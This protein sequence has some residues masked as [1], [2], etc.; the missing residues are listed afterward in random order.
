MK[1]Q[2]AVKGLLCLALLL[3]LQGRALAAVDIAV[4]SPWL[5]LMTRFIGGLQ[6][7]VHPL[8]GWDANGRV[9]RYSRP[10]GRFPVIALDES[11]ARSYGVR[12][13]SSKTLFE[14]LPGKGV[15]ESS[16]LDPS[17]LAFIGQRLL[18]TLSSIDPAN[19]AYYQR[20]LAEFQSRTDT[21][22]DV[23]RKLLHGLT[24]LDLTGASGKW[25]RAAVQSP[26]TPPEHV[27]ELW[28]KG[29]SLESLSVALRD[30]AAKGWIVVV[31]SWTPA[32][33]REKVTGTPRLARIPAPS[34]E[35][36]MLTQLNDFYLAIWNASG[37]RVNPHKP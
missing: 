32:T 34:L 6:V 12:P 35:R 5:S 26:I 13:Q 24:V 11:E 9:V 19:Y 1:N 31:D 36:E 23:G 4:T 22:V 30:A 25:I 10:S 8:S 29:K 18:G 15:K 20:R 28:N 27:M 7:K 33:V 17:S 14:S 21:T 37:R 2:A 16:F 3:L